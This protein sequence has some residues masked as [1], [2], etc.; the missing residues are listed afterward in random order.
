MAASA[1]ASAVKSTSMECAT[2]KR[3][4]KGASVTV[5]AEVFSTSPGAVGPKPSRIECIVAM[6][7]LYLVMRPGPPHCHVRRASGTKVMLKVA[8][9]EN[10]APKTHHG[11]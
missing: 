1:D 10:G 2:V 4:V 7:Q 9:K 6:I 3:A 8:A 5:E 11:E